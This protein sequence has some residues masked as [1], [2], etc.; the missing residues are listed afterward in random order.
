MKTNDLL[1]SFACTWG[2]MN[3]SLP[4]EFFRRKKVSE[5]RFNCAI[6]N[7]PFCVEIRLALVMRSDIEWH[8]AFSNNDLISS[9]SY[10]I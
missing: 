1:F 4:G 6:S 9:P 7:C 5:Y 10:V 2:L 8:E 3:L